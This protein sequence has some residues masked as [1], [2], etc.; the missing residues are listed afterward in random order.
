MLPLPSDLLFLGRTRIKSW[1]ELKVIE[2]LARSWSG[3]RA[4]EAHR[5]F[6]RLENKVEPQLDLGG[7]QC[8]VLVKAKVRAEL[9]GRTIGFDQDKRTDHKLTML[10]FMSSQEKPGAEGNCHG[11]HKR[12]MFT[13]GSRLLPFYLYKFPQ[14]IQPDCTLERREARQPIWEAMHLFEKV[15][16]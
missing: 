3:K 13:N 15:T 11:D 5:V 14:F 16:F 7:A 10:K 6:S 12:K 8:W 4:T 2:N 9:A 1:R